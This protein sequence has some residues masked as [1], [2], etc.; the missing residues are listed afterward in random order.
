MAD[1]NTT[2]DT[3]AKAADKQTEA[4][5]ETVKTAAREGERQVKKAGA[6]QRKAAARTARRAKTTRAKT[7]RAKAPRAKAARATTSRKARATRTERT[8]EMNFTPKNAFADFGAFPATA[9][10]EKLISEATVRG[11]EAAKRSR[12]AAEEL[13]DITRANVDAI[14]EAGRIATNGAQS[15]SQRVISKS[16]DNVELAANTVR[17]MAEAKT[18]ADLLQ[19][20]AEFVR[21][22]F[23]RIVEESSSLTESM[24]KL[25][26]ETFQP[27][28]NRATQ[29]VERI[30]DIIA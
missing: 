19:L 23:D 16:R 1:T 5:A 18:P 22:Y 28:Q 26:G 17:S 7:T 12:K 29:N 27:I 9:G 13:A 6:T 25:A 30:N 8:I 21:G 15:I 11:E 14:V 10:F 2:A 4:A 24:V 3:V 20:Q